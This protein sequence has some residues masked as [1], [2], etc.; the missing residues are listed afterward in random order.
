ME[1]EQL[2]G[3]VRR[4]LVGGGA[5]FLSSIEEKPRLLREGHAA[6]MDAADPR[7]RAEGLLFA[8]MGFSGVS[9]NLVKDAATRALATPFSIVKHYQIPRHVTAGWQTL[10]VSYSGMT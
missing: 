1:P 4:T 2:L 5:E 7:I 10:A 8:G 6:G 9:A 3:D